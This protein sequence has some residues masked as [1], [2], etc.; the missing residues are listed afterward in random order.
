MTKRKTYSCLDCKVYSQ[1]VFCLKGKQKSLDPP[2]QIRQ[3]KRGEYLFR[4]HEVS[5]GIFCLRKGRM[6]IQKNNTAGHTQLLAT[7][8]PGDILGTSSIFYGHTYST[9]A[10]ALTGSEA[11]FITRETFEELMQE[12]PS[13]SANTL[14]M[15]TRK[16]SKLEQPIH[17][18]TPEETCHT[19]Q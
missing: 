3:L 18:T 5:G 12:N 8:E 1:S 10:V 13:I 19:G 14:R 17:Q 4:E 7:A 9:S 11:C 2:K 15:L 16:L 6:L